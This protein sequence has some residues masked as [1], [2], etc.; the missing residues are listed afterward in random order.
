MTLLVLSDGANLEDD[1][2]KPLFGE[3]TLWAG[4]ETNL[5]GKLG[6]V[7][8]MGGES[9]AQVAGHEVVKA[10]GS[11]QHEMRIGKRRD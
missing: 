8:S 2:D 9:V 6:Q 10:V 1:E 11:N 7:E 3:I 5:L 4:D